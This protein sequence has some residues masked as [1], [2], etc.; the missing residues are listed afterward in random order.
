MPV[1]RSLARSALALAAALAITVCG[2]APAAAIVVEPEEP[3]G[4]ERA[5]ATVHPALV[6][7]T[8]TFVGRVHDRE[9]G[10]ANN[11]EPYTLVFMCTG[12]GVH[13]DGYIATVGHCIDANDRN[14]RDLFIRLAAE[15]AAAISPDIPLDQMLEV[16]RSAWD[17]EGTSP[18]SP[19]GSQ[20]LVTGV[21]GAPPEGMF[22][23]VVDSRPSGQGDVGLLKVDTT[24]LPALE[25]AT[26]PGIAVSMPLLAAGYP[27]SVGERIGPDATPSFEKGVVEQAGTDGGRPVYRTDTA[28]ELGLGGGPAFDASGRVHGINSVRLSGDQQVVNLVV[29]VSGFTDLLGRNG[30]RAELGQ[31]D[32]RYREALDANDRGEYTDVIEAIDRLEQEGS[33]H[34]R[35]AELRRDAEASRALHG[36]ASENRT[37][38]ILVWGSVGTGAIVLVVIGALLVARRRRTTPVVM[39][40]P[41]AFPRPQ[42]GPPWQGGPFP[43]PARQP[44]PPNRPYGAAPFP[45]QAGPRPPAAA[46]GRPGP[47]AQ[48]RGAFDGPTRQIRFPQPSPPGSENQTTAIA[49]P[50]PSA[51]APD[52]DD[53]KDA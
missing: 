2:A 6:R 19:I 12:F 35:V 45:R 44:A 32:V 53:A 28:I 48:A 38:Q 39:V 31:R 33:T 9:G 40:P 24:D 52:K 26:G 20:I 43:P 22:A 34:P 46:P 37:T 21:A 17:I 50:E 10:Y 5:A 3:A 42:P 29:P 7:V 27:E 13:P 18:G 30:V 4:S 47:A 41:P 11:G 8:G 16:G 49:A 36:D 51:P 25:L 15:D 23:R 1:L 14:V